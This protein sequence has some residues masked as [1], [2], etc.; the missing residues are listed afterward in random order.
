MKI[1]GVRRMV[2]EFGNMVREARKDGVTVWINRDETGC[3][4][5][6]FE[7]DL[8]V[9]GECDEVAR[10]AALK[11]WDEEVNA[12]NEVAAGSSDAE[13]A[14]DKDG[15]QVCTTDDVDRIKREHGRPEVIIT[16]TP[17]KKKAD[18]ERAQ[19]IVNGFPTPT[20]QDE[21]EKEARS[22]A[23]SPIPFRTGKP[24]VPVEN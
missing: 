8:V 24:T 18:D 9:R 13:A 19:R 4:A 20:S 5:N 11:R 1:P 15:F 23:M 6:A 12:A 10:L 2:K 22:R 16:Q 3:G 14:K 7:W 17:K 21:S